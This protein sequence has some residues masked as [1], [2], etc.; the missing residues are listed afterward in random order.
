MMDIYT[1]SAKPRT[2]PQ[3]PHQRPLMDQPTY[4]TASAAKPRLEASAR[5]RDVFDPIPDEAAYAAAFIAGAKAEGHA[6][7][8]PVM[9]KPRGNPTG[10]LNEAAIRI[11]Y[12]L[13]NGP[14]RGRELR[15]KSGLNYNTLKLATD[16]MKARG[17]I[18]SR[19]LTAKGASIY[20]VCQP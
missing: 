5:P 11:K 20:E 13:R 12:A 17:E 8:L 15:S 2:A 3:R 1:L 9:H 16:A 6:P 4:I 7:G 10:D 14:L 18:K 19:L